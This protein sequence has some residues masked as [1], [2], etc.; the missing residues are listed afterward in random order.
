[1]GLEVR[2]LRFVGDQDALEQAGEVTVVADRVVHRGPVVPERD[3]RRQLQ[4]P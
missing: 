4:P 2:V 3:G 1:M